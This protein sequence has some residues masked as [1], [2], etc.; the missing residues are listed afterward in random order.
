MRRLWF[1]SHVVTRCV[2]RASVVLKTFATGSAL[3]AALTLVHR[4]I[5]PQTPNVS[6][7][8]RFSLQETVFA[9]LVEIT[10]R[11]VIDLIITALWF[12]SVCYAGRWLMWAAKRCV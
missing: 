9:M 7:F 3:I 12:I 6:Y 1:T 5:L 4:L 10:E 11:C 2:G 8:R